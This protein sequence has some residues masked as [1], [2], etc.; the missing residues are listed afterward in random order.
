MRQ[1]VLVGVNPDKVLEG[2]GDSGFLVG[3]ELWQIDEYVSGNDG[4]RYAVSV[5]AS[6]VGGG[7]FL[8]VVVGAVVAFGR[9]PVTVE[10]RKIA[11]VELDRAKRV[12]WKGSPVEDDMSV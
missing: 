3:L 4:P 11:Q 1:E 6:R 9:R 12:P 7:R 10:V 2:T 8:D 5:I